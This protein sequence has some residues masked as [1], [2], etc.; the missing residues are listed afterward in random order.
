[1]L[2][3]KLILNTGWKVTRKT[4]LKTE[5]NCS[6]DLERLYVSET[7]EKSQLLEVRPERLT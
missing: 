7:M 2:P 6:W 4:E 1:M 3:K 5:E